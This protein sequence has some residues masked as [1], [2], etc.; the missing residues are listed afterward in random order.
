MAFP[1]LAPE[2]LRKMNA[3]TAGLSPKLADEGGYRSFAFDV[4]VRT[5]KEWDPGVRAHAGFAAAG[6]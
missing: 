5:L 4:S 6:L 2:E 3:P 1:G